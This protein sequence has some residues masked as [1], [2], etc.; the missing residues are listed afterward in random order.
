V[1]RKI[2]ETVE[3]IEVLMK[4]SFEKFSLIGM[5]HEKLKGN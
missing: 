4:I 1:F 5:N 3:K 2:V